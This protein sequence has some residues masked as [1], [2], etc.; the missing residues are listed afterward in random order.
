MRQ[1]N[2]WIVWCSFQ[3]LYTLSPLA[4]I[5][6]SSV[7]FIV[8][9]LV[10]NTFRRELCRMIGFRRYATVPQVNQSSTANARL[11]NINRYIALYEFLF[12]TNDTLFNHYELAIPFLFSGRNLD[13]RVQWKQ[14]PQNFF[15][16]HNRWQHQQGDGRQLFFRQKSEQFDGKPPHQ[17]QKGRCNWK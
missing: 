14:G 15:S 2:T 7:N 12:S 4:M 9:C 10:G 17:E 8:Y 16:G 3:V 13:N 11:R 1:Q 6:N 5:L